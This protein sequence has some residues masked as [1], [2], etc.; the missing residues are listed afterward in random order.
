[1]AIAYL[2]DEASPDEIGIVELDDLTVAVNYDVA[3]EISLEV[4]PEFA[5]GATFTVRDGEFASTMPAPQLP[6]M[7]LEERKAADAAYLESLRLHGRDDRRAAG[8]AGGG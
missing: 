7:T 3:A 6:E 4:D 8:G 5:E 2:N 1:M